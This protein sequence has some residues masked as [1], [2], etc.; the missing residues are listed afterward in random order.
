M[1]LKKL[2]KI[3]HLN[4]FIEIENPKIISESRMKKW[5]SGNEI[6]NELAEY[7]KTDQKSVALDMH[8]SEK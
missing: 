7:G 2:T 4:K 3:V 6:V 5:E 1:A 8:L